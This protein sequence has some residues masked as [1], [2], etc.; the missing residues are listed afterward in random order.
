M[1][2]AAK[3]SP[4]VPPTAKIT[5][6]KHARKVTSAYHKITAQM[7]VAGS[8][9]ELAACASELAEMGGVMAYQQAS[10]LNTA[11]NKT[12]AWVV[13]VLRQRKLLKRGA[14]LRVLEVGAINTQLLEEPELATRAIDLHAIN[15]HIEQCDFFSLPYGGELDAATGTSIPYDA[16]VCSMVLNC[17]PEPRRRFEMLVGLRAQL[18][19][20][21][22]CF[23]TVP[24]SCLQH[25][26]TLT[27]DTFC[28]CLVAVGLIPVAFG[29]ASA[30]I[31]F[32]ECNAA[33]PDA[34]AALRFQQARHARR[35]A[36][37]EV[38]RVKSR[39][40]HFDV[41]LG[42]YLGMGVRVGRSHETTDYTRLAKE[43][44]LLN[45]HLLAEFKLEDGVAVA[46]AAA[47][48]RANTD[49]TAM[50]A[51][52][53]LRSVL[54]V[55]QLAALRSGKPAEV[56]IDADEEEDGAGDG[57]ERA[58]ISELLER[59]DDA[60]LDFSHWRWYGGGSGDRGWLHVRPG[61]A[62]P[63]GAVQQT[64][65]WQWG[66]TGW[67][68]AEPRVSSRSELPL[69]HAGRAAG[70]RP[71]SVRL[72]PKQQL[73]AKRAKPMPGHAPRGWPLNP[74]RK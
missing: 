49:L 31:A 56:T 15:S 39:G 67:A 1:G 36:T 47:A 66:T 45:A 14:R 61:D 22:V 74:L 70:A 3:K 26:F 27:H 25:S 62:A 16:V 58:R 50:V 18:R 57:E 52:E 24:R 11:L 32:Y 48:G 42:G 43:Q 44:G 33:S 59:E 21:G 55:R 29:K 71:L 72:W 73:G 23:I 46:A 37:R 13:Q 6:R 64:S 12:S 35:R 65:G 17:V 63:P 34:E 8:A 20:G 5:S 38:G 54:S 10:A 19:T 60:K 2:K 30:K 40:A 51:R 53:G 9:S 69:A 68:Y 28:E 7:K 41:D 4:I